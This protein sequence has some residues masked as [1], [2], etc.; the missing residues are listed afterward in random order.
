MTKN[1]WQVEWD[2]L[3]K[4]EKAYL[5]RGER[6]K[7]S[8]LN[9]F[10]EEKV[11]PKLQDTLDAAFAKAFALIFE[12]GTGVIEK[13]YNRDKAERQFKLN[14]FAVKL[15]EDKKGL[16]QFS[17]SAA[18]AGQW[19][20]LLSGIEGVG[21]GA[22]GVGLPDI[23][24][25]VGVLLKSLYEMSLRYGCGYDSAEE[26]YFIL[27]LI[28]TSLSHGDALTAGDGRINDFIESGLLPE[29]YS[30]SAQIDR[31]AAA[32]STELLYM[33]FL[34]GIPIVGAVGGAYDAVYLQKVQKY[35]KLK[36]TRRFLTDHEK[37]RNA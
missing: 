35:A 26:K 36:Y 18:Q 10:L 24:L 11:P 7:A 27:M 25:F 29:N 9:K 37:S 4:S 13:T 20:L 6:Q 31:A 22:F 12:K 23:P 21:L 16:R 28:E 17:K 33:K 2:S 1:P 32:L 19:N 8:I 5:S 30:Q 14:S 15:K 34:Q 3:A